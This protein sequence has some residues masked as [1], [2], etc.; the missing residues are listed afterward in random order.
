MG[1]SVRTHARTQQQETVNSGYE[2]Q[3]QGLRLRKITRGVHRDVTNAFF[4]SK[5]HMVLSCKC[6]RIFTYALR[7]AQLSVRRFSRNRQTLNSIIRR[8]LNN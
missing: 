3:H 4:T 5:C 1:I 8:Y 7:Q 6:K 2:A